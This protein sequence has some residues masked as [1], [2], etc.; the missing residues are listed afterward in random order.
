LDWHRV[1]STCCLDECDDVVLAWFRAKKRIKTQQP[2][3]PLNKSIF[4]GRSHHQNLSEERNTRLLDI[5]DIEFIRRGP[6]DEAAP[7]KSS[8]S[9]LKAW[10][11]N[12]P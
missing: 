5:A 7:D 1:G 12:T 8:T 4:W 2:P 11:K 10:S 9:T 3:K 6:P